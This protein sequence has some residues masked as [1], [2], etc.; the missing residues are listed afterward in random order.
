M[1]GV[2]V[3]YEI[4]GVVVPRRVAGHLALDF[5]NTYAGWGSS[6]GREYLVDYDALVVWAGEAGLVSS[7]EVPRL[8]RH[9]RADGCAAR[10]TLERA[11]DLRAALHEVITDPDHWTG[12]E[13]VGSAVARAA[14]RARIEGGPRPRWVAA[15]GLDRPLDA[16]ALAAADLLT[17]AP[18][19]DV[20]SCPGDGCGW[21]FLD[22]RGRRRWCR[23]EWCGNRAKVRAH[24]ERSRRAASG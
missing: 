6:D 21:M 12:I 20:R 19:D 10:R 2:Q 22:P 18:L 23:M 1:S 15:D 17:R 9:A 11:V 8:Q 16:A 5:V 7:S 13:V 14:G 4:D 3:R 24:A